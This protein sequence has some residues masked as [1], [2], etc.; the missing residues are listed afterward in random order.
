MNKQRKKANKLLP[1]I[2]DAEFYFS[3]GVK[4][5]QKQKFDQSVRWLTKAIDS[6]PTNP[7][8]KCQLSVVYTETGKYHRANQ[9]LNHVLQNNDY[10]DCYYLLANNYAHLGLLNDSMK[11]AKTYLEKEPEGEFGEEAVMLMELIEFELEDEELDDWLLEE[12]DDLLKYQETV[13]YMMENEEWQKAIPLIHEMLL[14]FPDHLIVRHDYAQALFYTGEEQKA[15]DL[16]MKIFK[17]V[18]HSLHSM[19]NLALFYYESEQHEAY[20]KIINELI[21]V[22]PLHADQQIKLAVTM[23]K[24]GNYD[25]AYR[26][27]TRINRGMA[28]GHLSFYKW[29]SIT[30]YHIGKKELAF[31][32]WEDGCLKHRALQDH[33]APWQES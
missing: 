10:V 32:L 31:D 15:I 27:F 6:D 29:F 13:F 4:A 19:I 2:P 3:K 25:V 21:H 8:Y 33:V 9:L 28:R 30:C 23:A 7:L 26:R 11:Y 5:F 16:E 24:T 20:E 22:Y 14:L 17:E 18:G 1:F 12:E